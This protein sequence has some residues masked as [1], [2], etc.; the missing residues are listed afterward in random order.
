MLCEELW[1]CFSWSVAAIHTVKYHRVTSAIACDF[2]S[3]PRFQH[4]NVSVHLSA[5]SFRPLLK[6]QVNC[7]QI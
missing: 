2:S 3:V 4:L 6:R 1:K 7:N 5:D